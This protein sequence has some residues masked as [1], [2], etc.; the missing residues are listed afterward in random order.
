MQRRMF[1][2]D[3]GAEPLQRLPHLLPPLLLLLHG[4]RLLEEEG[5]GS[6]V[7]C[8]TCRASQ[9]R[10]GQQWRWRS[11]VTDRDCPCLRLRLRQDARPLRRAR[12]L[13]QALHHGCDA[14]PQRAPLR[15]SAAHASAWR[16]AVAVSS[17][18]RRSLRH[19]P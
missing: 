18:S 13:S 11:H 19:Q 4:K 8:L 15:R 10:H 2:I 1:G 6:A 17:A 14:G 9:R 5:A 7:D 3:L 12:C 16:A